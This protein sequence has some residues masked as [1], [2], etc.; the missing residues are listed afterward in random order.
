MGRQRN[1][2]SAR[3]WTL[4]DPRQNPMSSTM[5]GELFSK[6]RRR[7]KTTLRPSAAATGF[8]TSAPRRRYTATTPGSCAS[9]LRSRFPARAPA[10]ST[11]L[12]PKVQYERS[13]LMGSE[14]LPRILE[15]W[16]KVPRASSSR[17]HHVRPQGARKALE[18]F[19][20]ECVEEIVDRELEP[21]CTVQEVCKRAAARAPS[22]FVGLP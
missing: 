18:E 1:S 20:L 19:A 9:A 21:L 10:L 2:S 8:P 14:E 15:R 22:D 13:A 6:T 3:L 16:Y 17:H 12:N 11:T 5:D 7:T 4:A